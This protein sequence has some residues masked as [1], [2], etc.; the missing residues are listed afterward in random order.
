MRQ[1]GISLR[2]CPD[3][4]ELCGLDPCRR[5]AQRQRQVPVRRTGQARHPHRDHGTAPR[6]P[7]G[8]CAG[9]HRPADE[10]ARARQEHR[11]LGI[12]LLR[13]ASAGTVHPLRHDQ[14]GPAR[15][16]H[17]NL[18]ALQTPHGRGT[19]VHGGDGHP[20]DGIPHDQLHGLQILHALPVGYRHPRHL[21]AL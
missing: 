4:D 21:P 14:H 13:Y 19:G 3:R 2:L 20:D 5:R 10:R 6:R 11:F 17:Q 1:R 18:H 16:Q 7:S 9:R 15:G 12:P 8:Q